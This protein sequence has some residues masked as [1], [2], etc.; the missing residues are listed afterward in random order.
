MGD[1]RVVFDAIN[2]RL[3]NP[4][5]PEDL[6]QNDDVDFVNEPNQDGNSKPDAVVQDANNIHLLKPDFYVDD[7]RKKIEDTDWAGLAADIEDLWHPSEDA[8]SDQW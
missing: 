7:F 4:P 5:M 6:V 2:A 8:V 1:S 3:G